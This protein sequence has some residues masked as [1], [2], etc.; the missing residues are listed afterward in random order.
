MY[1]GP[2]MRCPWRCHE[3]GGP[4]I[5][6][7]PSCPFHGSDRVDLEELTQEDGDRMCAEQ[8]ALNEPSQEESDS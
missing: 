8:E 3:I 7:N 4:W 1:D 5:S 2:P 6:Y